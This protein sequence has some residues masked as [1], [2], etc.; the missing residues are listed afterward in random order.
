MEYMSKMCYSPISGDDLNKLYVDS[1][2]ELIS[3]L[4]NNREYIYYF[5]RYI[6]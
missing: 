6:N 5:K 2:W 3:T 1:G 4:F